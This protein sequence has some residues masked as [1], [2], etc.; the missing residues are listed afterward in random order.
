MQLN[1]KR[2]YVIAGI[3]AAVI[4]AATAGGIA[5]ATDGDE[6]PLTGETYD[7][8]VAAA[9][10]HTGGGEVTETEVGD[11]GAAYE[12]EVLL[13]NGTQ[14]E[15]ELDENFTVIGDSPDDDSDDDED[16]D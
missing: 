1:F 5:I 7:R 2:R 3:A 12:V 11:D 6:Q 10:A 4:A 13:D 15:I 9:L 14:L 16:D 8:A